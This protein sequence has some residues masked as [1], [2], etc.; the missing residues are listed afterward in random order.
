MNDF[1]LE[2][3][4]IVVDNLDHTNKTDFTAHL[5]VA[6]EDVV[7]AA[8]AARPFI[9]TNETFRRDLVALARARGL[10]REQRAAARAKTTG[11][12][13]TLGG[14]GCADGCAQSYELREA[15]GDDA[16]LDLGGRD[17]KSA[18]CVDGGAASPSST[19]PSRFR[20]LWK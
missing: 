2:E 3:H 11:A 15:L 19:R 6:L 1:D 10:L 8:F 7:E 9:L 17:A 20:G 16:A 18:Q 14:N 4:T 5:P 13:E 12:A